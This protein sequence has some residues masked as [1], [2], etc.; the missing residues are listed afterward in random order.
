MQRQ[1]PRLNALVRFVHARCGIPA[2]QSGQVLDSAALVVSDVAGLTDAIQAHR[3]AV[4]RFSSET[5]TKCV[6]S[7]PTRSMNLLRDIGELCGHHMV[8]VRLRRNICNPLFGDGSKASPYAESENRLLA[9]AVKNLLAVAS[10]E[11]DDTAMPD[12][13]PANVPLDCLPELQVQLKPLSDYIMKNFAGSFGPSVPGTP[14]VYLGAG[15]QQTPLHFDPTENLTLVLQGMKSFRLY[16]P[17]SSSQLQPQGGWLAA[18]FCWHH[19]FVPAVYSK[20]DPFKEVV[21]L[22]PCIEFKL[23]AGELLYLP[24]AWWHA[25]SGSKDANVT[26]VFG[27]S[28]DFSKAINS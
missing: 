11:S 15:G 21:N 26:V 23:H 4:F 10:N 2:T 20:L 9:H 27:F 14:V 6:H 5:L 25:V 24:S 16:P 18:A 13:Y 28:P 8:R 3:P 12:C 1:H 22:P 19:G 17:S 7:K